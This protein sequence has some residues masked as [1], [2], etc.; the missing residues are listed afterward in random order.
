MTQR[1]RS[2]RARQKWQRLVSEQGRSGLSVAAFCRE[3]GMCAPHFFAW[4]KR[5]QEAGKPDGAGDSR[6]KFVEVKLAAGPK[7]LRA[8]GLRPPAGDSRVEVVLANGRSLRVGPGFDAGHVRALL[9]VVE[10]VA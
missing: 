8:T 9:A 5:L 10:G 4:K 1:E 7:E 6:E 2:R 3:R